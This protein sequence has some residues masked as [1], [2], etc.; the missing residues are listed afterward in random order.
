M[1]YLLA[2]AR[3][4][5][6]AECIP[7]PGGQRICGTALGLLCEFAPASP[8]SMPGAKNSLPNSLPAGNL[9][10]GRFGLYRSFDRIRPYR[11]GRDEPG[12]TRPGFGDW[13]GLA[14]ASWRLL[15][16]LLREPAQVHGVGVARIDV[17]LVIDADTLQRAERLGFLDEAGNLAVLGVADPDA[18]LEA[19]IGL[20]ARL[21]VGHVED[22]VLVDPHAAGSAELLPFG[23]E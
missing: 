11:D 3:V 22:V 18:L 9:A 20:L 5:A 21:R 17:A 7:C 16:H 15:R 6:R 12:P 4:S 14:N 1:N 8:K 23:K 19:R 2:N 13:A 10:S